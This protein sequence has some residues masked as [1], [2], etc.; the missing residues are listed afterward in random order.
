MIEQ[1][2]R[3][4]GRSEAGDAEY[5][6]RDR[7]VAHH[8]LRDR[9]AEAALDRRLLDRDDCAGLARCG[10]DRGFVKRLDRRNID[11]ARV[12]ALFGEDIRRGERSR[13]HRAGRHHRHVR[14]S[15][16]HV[17][18]P[19]SESFG[20]LR[21]HRRDFCAADTDVAGRCRFRRPTHCGDGLRR[22]GRARRC[23]A[24]QW[25]AASSGPRSSD[26]SA[27]ARHRPCPELM[28][29]STTGKPL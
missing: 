6:H 2:R 14:A 20:A 9:R 27:R 19:E 23:R 11:D 29:Q 4:S 25:R 24:R 12:Q 3:S 17:G 22:I 18:A 1:E 28:P 16:Q 8:R 10:D 26:E 13:Y 21:C 7:G 5:A 15:A